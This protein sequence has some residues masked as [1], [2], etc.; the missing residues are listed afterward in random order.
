MMM[1]IM[2]ITITSPAPLLLVTFCF[3][4]RGRSLGWCFWIV[5]KLLIP[6]EMFSWMEWGSGKT[7]GDEVV[8]GRECRDSLIEIHYP[9]KGNA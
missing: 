6:W 4:S 2:S 1:M 7:E 8:I 9:A 5:F 3:K